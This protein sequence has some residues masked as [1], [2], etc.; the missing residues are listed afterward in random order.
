METYH[1]EAECV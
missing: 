1:I